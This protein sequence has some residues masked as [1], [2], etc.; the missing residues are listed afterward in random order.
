MP[1]DAKMKIILGCILVFLIITM[2]ACTTDIP[3]S[4]T[5]AVASEQATGQWLF[6]NG[7]KTTIIIAA[8]NTRFSDCCC[9][10]TDYS[11]CTCEGIE[12]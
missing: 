3:P 9:V 11:V 12:K 10:G 1:G 4:Q 8:N 2:A 7:F 6:I 5:C